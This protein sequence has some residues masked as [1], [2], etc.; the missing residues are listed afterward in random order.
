MVHTLAI[1]AVFL[2]GYRSTQKENKVTLTG[3]LPSSSSRNS[4]PGSEVAS[5]SQNPMQ[6][7]AAFSSCAAEGTPRSDLTCG[8]VANFQVIIGKS[9]E[10]SCVNIGGYNCCVPKCYSNT[11]K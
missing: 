3:C 10:G 5:S 6:G 9:Y 11:Q 1:L 8:E 2:D 7:G 4:L